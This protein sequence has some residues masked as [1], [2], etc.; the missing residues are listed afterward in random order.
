MRTSLAMATFSV[1]LWCVPLAA[2]TWVGT[3]G[4][5]LEVS[6]RRGRPV[7]GA[8]VQLAYAETEEGGGPGTV[9]TDAEGRAAV[10]GLAEGGWR[11]QVSHPDHMAYLA[12][13]RVR[14]NRRPR[15]ETAS[16]VKVGDSL[17]P[18]RV[19]Y[20]KVEG[21]A[22]RPAPAPE[23]AP[24]PVAPPAPPPP[25]PPPAPEASPVPEPSPPTPSPE[26]E[27]APAPPPAAPPAP[28]PPPEPALLPAA[29]AGSLRSFRDG[30]CPECQPG[31]WVAA[32]EVRAGGPGEGCPEDLAER[33]AEAAKLLASADGAAASH[34][35]PVGELAPLAPF[36]AD[37]SRCRVAALHLPEGSRFVGFVYEAGGGTW[38][39]CQIGDP[40][41][42]GG[43][44]WVGGPL[45][46]TDAA[47][48]LVVAAYENV[49]GA[50]PRPVRLTVFWVP[51]A[52]WS[53]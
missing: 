16:L 53:P 1:A 25:P 28:A 9:R 52:Q 30:T 39:P 7:A 44:R 37:G 17:E 47:G 19:R 34:G 13:V 31:E 42:P 8:E 18:V 22:P 10:R 51:P 27:P 26:P 32:V 46:E 50:P 3:A 48:T 40:C 4:I 29:P 35:G 43:G 12:D 45:L 49:P 36:Q 11:L 20:F 5:G 15:E 23:P 33:A 38:M 24:E 21:M 2:Q 14:S 6:D 41:P